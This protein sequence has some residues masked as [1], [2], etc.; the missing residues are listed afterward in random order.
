MDIA[1]NL[2][3]HPPTL[4][5]DDLD[6]TFRQG[7]LKALA[8]L[9]S[10]GRTFTIRGTLRPSPYSHV[11]DDLRVGPVGY[12][13]LL[14]LWERRGLAWQVISHWERVT[15]DRIKAGLPVSGRSHPDVK[16]ARCLVALAQAGTD[17]MALRQ[18]MRAR[19]GKA[20]VDNA[21]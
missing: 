3:D 17:P 8:S 21:K 15:L 12:S 13:A 11:E 16:A 10:E 1:H 9:V 2:T 18:V 19:A 20:W 5:A 7:R 6:R 4:T 14:I